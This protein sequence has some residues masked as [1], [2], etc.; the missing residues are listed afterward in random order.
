LLRLPRH[1]PQSLVAEMA[2][3]AEPISAEAAL[4]HGLIVRMCE[5][6]GRSTWGSS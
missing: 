4:A 2:L 3:T 1:L 6:G 5:W